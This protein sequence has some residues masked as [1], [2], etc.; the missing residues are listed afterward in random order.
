MASSGYCPRS[1]DHGKGTSSRRRFWT[2]P[3][4]V[5]P[6]GLGSGHPGTVRYKCASTEY[7][8]TG[9]RRRARPHGIDRYAAGC[10]VKLSCSAHENLKLNC[11]PNL[12]S[13]GRGILAGDASPRVICGRL[14]QT[15]CTTT[16]V[17]Q[18]L[19]L[20]THWDTQGASVLV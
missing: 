18:Q 8:T 10:G 7:R 14:P 3:S 9:G 12:L 15:F 17:L 11:P 20:Q 2:S 19:V 6:P 4:F 13:A 1:E 16:L 5:A